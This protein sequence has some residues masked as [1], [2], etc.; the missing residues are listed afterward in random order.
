MGL[1]MPPTS[2]DNPTT[3]A[4]LTAEEVADF[5]NKSV[6]WVYKHWQELG[7]AKFG[8]SIFFPRQGDIYERIFNQKRDMAVQ[9]QPPRPAVHRIR[10][11]DQERGK[12]SGSKK[13]GRTREPAA[14]CG[15]AN[16]HGL[17]GAG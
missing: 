1:A 16:R 17:L 15:E 3:S 2:T 7:G 10:V 9:L 14:D 12:G 8:G 5:L 4:V 13:E 11:Q 6:S